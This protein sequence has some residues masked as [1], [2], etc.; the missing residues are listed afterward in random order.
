VLLA[1]AVAFAADNSDTLS[2]A[3]KQFNADT[4]AQGLEG[5]LKWF[6]EDGYVGNDPSVRGSDALR[7]FYTHLFSNKDLNFQWSPSHS[8]LFPSGNMGYTTGRYTMTFTDA[9]GNKVSRT[10]NYLTVWQKQKDGSWKVLSDF[11]SV[12]ATPK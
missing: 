10:G 2:K 5:W 7:Q 1:S 11:G 9:K 8:E 4:R 3:D 12:D 6:A